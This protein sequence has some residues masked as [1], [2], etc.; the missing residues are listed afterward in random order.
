[1]SDEGRTLKR[2]LP[3]NLV[4]DSM[5]RIELLPYEL[6]RFITGGVKS[7]IE[8]VGGYS[9]LRKGYIKLNVNFALL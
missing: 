2:R 5:N 7:S 6:G 8:I 9:Q 1:M 4:V 3:L